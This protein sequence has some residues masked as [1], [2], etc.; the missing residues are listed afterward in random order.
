MLNK[1]KVDRAK[2]TVKMI[3]K[4]SNVDNARCHI[5]ALFQSRRIDII[6]SSLL[7]DYL[8]SLKRREDILK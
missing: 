6:E 1:G 3:F 4:S 8:D 7:H 5:R 2:R